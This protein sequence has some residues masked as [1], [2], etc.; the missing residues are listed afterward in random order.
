M[1]NHSSIPQGDWQLKALCDLPTQAHELKNFTLSLS[2]EGSLSGR[3][4]VNNFSG[5]VDLD[6]YQ[7]SLDLQIGAST[8]MAYPNERASRL[9]QH[10]TG[11]LND[12]EGYE[13]GGNI[14]RLLDA[15]GKP[16]A[17]FEKMSNELVDGSQWQLIGYNNGKGGVVSDEYAP[18][19]TA[20]FKPDGTI[21]GTTGEHGY[22]A[23]FQANNS[24]DLEVSS[25]QLSPHTVGEN[26]PI[27]E[28]FLNALAASQRYERVGDRLTLWDNNGA[29]TL[30]FRKIG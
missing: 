6:P 16:V 22:R 29:R 17:T 18:R 7:H 1:I 20:M 8:L 27:E 30:D 23:H 25:T 5:T 12:A 9:A 11:L 14:L 4:G 26:N 13:L 3:D 28:Q 10:Y 15:S 2:N 24:G 19:I 21:A